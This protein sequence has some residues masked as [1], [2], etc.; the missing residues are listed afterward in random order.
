MHNCQNIKEELLD[1]LFGEADAAQTARLQRELRFCNACRAEYAGMQKTF[2]EYEKF[3]ALDVPEEN[4]WQSYEANL[5]RKLM[6]VDSPEP[7]KSFVAD[8]C[9]KFLT[10]QIRIPVPVAAGF[11]VL[12]VSAAFLNLRLPVEQAQTTQTITEPQIQ[13]VPVDRE[14]IVVHE[15]TVWRDRVVT[16]K[17]YVPQRESGIKNPAALTARAKRKAELLEATMPLLNLAEFQPP[18]KVEPK[19]VA[20]GAYGGK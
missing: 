12:F 20:E 10:A 11:A 16:Q 13:L 14:K 18:A 5:S 9:R 19:I 8:F 6:S 1:L 3:S 15:K 2:A 17:I 7:K 4:Y